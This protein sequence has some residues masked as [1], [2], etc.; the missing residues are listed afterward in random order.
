LLDFRLA[1]HSFRTSSFASPT[2]NPVLNPAAGEPKATI[3]LEAQ[4]KTHLL[5]ELMLLRA[6][7]SYV[8]TGAAANTES[9]EPGIEPPSGFGRLMGAASQVVIKLG[10]VFINLSFFP[11]HCQQLLP[12]W[13]L[14]FSFQLFE[15]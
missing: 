1:D 9:A 8:E 4:V 12:L 15:S 2:R 11:Q 7:Q 14:Q 10:Q 6:L 3:Y 5:A 13:S